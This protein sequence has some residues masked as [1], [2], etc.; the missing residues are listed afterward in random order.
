MFTTANKL[1]CIER[2]LKFRHS[3]Y[4]R[5]VANGTMSEEFAHREIA[6]MEDIAADYRERL[7]REGL[8]F[9][10]EHS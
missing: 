10:E 2:E 8:P 3:V 4:G 9:E 5:R 1:K 7:N 6:L